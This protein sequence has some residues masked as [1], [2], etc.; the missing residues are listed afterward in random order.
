VDWEGRAVADPEELASQFRPGVSMPRIA[1]IIARTLQSEPTPEPVLS[2]DEIMGWLKGCEYVRDIVERG[3][4]E[5]WQLPLEF[6]RTRRGDCED[7][8]LW[9]WRKCIDLCVPARFA[10]GRGPGGGGHAWVQV[11]ARENLILETTEKRR[12]E[13]GLIPLSRAETRYRVAVSIDDEG[14]YY[15]HEI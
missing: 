9:A 8:A 5:H 11:Y 6:E 14:R 4:V 10:I 2:V 3:I 12:N 15:R 13:S 7:H 1:A